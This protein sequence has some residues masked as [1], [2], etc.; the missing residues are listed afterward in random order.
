MRTRY[1]TNCSFWDILK[2]SSSSDSNKR[3]VC[4]LFLTSRR[5][6]VLPRLAF[7]YV[8]ALSDCSLFFVDSFSAPKNFSFC[9]YMSSASSC[10][11][12]ESIQFSGAF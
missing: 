7:I 11:E 9:S 6:L 4:T 5:A 2:L 8:F 1:T 10:P 3:V 12:G